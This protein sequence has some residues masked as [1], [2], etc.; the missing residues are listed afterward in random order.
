MS[1]SKINHMQ[2]IVIFHMTMYHFLI[3]SA[4]TII[5]TANTTTYVYAVAILICC[6][7]T[8]VVARF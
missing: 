5:L 7:L 4:N 8:P 3:V 1:Y 6:Y 2:E